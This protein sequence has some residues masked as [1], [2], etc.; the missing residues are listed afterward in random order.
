LASYRRAD[1]VP[2]RERAH[3]HRAENEELSTFWPVERCDRH[4]QVADDTGLVEDSERQLVSPR[5][6]V[7]AQA[8]DQ[9]SLAR[10]V[11]GIS[12]NTVAALLIPTLLDANH[13]GLT[14][15]G[16]PPLMWW[17]QPVISRR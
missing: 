12:K 16:L 6:A 1:P 8:R 9:L 7:Q 10:P 2:L 3:G 5:S 15:C 17:I 11:E 14:H 4:Q 13:Y